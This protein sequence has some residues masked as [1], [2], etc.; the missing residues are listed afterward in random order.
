[1]YITQALHRSVRQHPDRIAIR[2]GNRTR[3]FREL[4]ERVARF[5]AA[6]RQAGLQSGRPRRHA[7]PQ[8]G[9]IP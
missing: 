2:F 9:S 1:M 8:L 4:N 6:V 3:T 7:S 5:A